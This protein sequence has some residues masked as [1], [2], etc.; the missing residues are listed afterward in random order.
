MTALFESGDVERV[1]SE[2][3]QKIAVT[4]NNLRKTFSGVSQTVAVDDFTYEVYEGE[5]L[6]I[7][8]HNGAGKTTMMNMLTGILTP[9]SGTAL[10]Y[11][12]NVA[13]PKELKQARGMIGFCPQHNVLFEDFNVE[14][15][16]MFFARLKGFTK[17]QAQIEVERILS[18]I[19]MEKEAKVQAR[20]LSGGQKRR[21]S[22]AIAVIGNPKVLILDEPS[23]GVDVYSQRFLWDMIRNFRR[24]RCVIITTQSMMEADLLADRKLIMSHGKLRCAG[25]S[26]FL[27]HR[28]GLG[29][30]LTMAVKKGCDENEINYSVKQIVPGAERTRSHAGELCFV[31]PKSS[32]KEYPRLFNEIDSYKSRLGIESYGVSLTTMEEI[33]LR[34]ADE[35]V[36]EKT[37]LKTFGQRVVLSRERSYQPMESL[38]FSVPKKGEVPVWRKFLAL[39]KIRM[40]LMIR[41]KVAVLFQLIIPLFFICMLGS[42]VIVAKRSDNFV[43]DEDAL[44]S[45]ELRKSFEETGTK[46]FF[47]NRTGKQ[48]RHKA[49]FKLVTQITEKLVDKE[50]NVSAC[51]KILNF[52]FC[53]Y[54]LNGNNRHLSTFPLLNV[55]FSSFGLHRLQ[56]FCYTE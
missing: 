53:L 6:A 12:K 24:N 41:S 56:F 9:T 38:T 49:F 32:L 46:F 19:G 3:R 16:L 30:Y 11:G 45:E 35:D 29:Y 44:S 31:L 22:I 21:L 51:G 34:L 20:S 13:Y 10:I 8:G 7:L 39:C 23:S 26:L 42:V 27:K 37:D 2:L 33:F 5:I 50:M 15:H 48:N 40:L 43:P 28:F 25:T 4:M 52:G 14:E 17:K 18:E 54:D 1:S 36:E 55:S 47:E